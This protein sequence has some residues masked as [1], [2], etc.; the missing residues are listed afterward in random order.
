[1]NK[2]ASKR[3]KPKLNS[4]KKARPVT[5]ENADPV[6]GTSKDSLDVGMLDHRQ[7]RY[8]LAIIEE[9]H[10]SRAA[11]KL[12][13]SKQGMSQ[14]I[15]ALEQSLDA[16]LFE[17]GQFG[18][19]PTEFGRVLATH[20]HVIFA[21]GRKA[22]SEI[23]MLKLEH[24]GE[25]TFALGSSFSQWIGPAAIV[26]FSAKNPGVALKVANVHPDN[27]LKLLAEGQLD[28]IA[29]GDFADGELPKGVAR[30]KLFTTKDRVICAKTTYTKKRGHV[31]LR[32]LSDTK[33]VT[34]WRNDKTRQFIEGA[35]KGEGF[36]NSPSFTLCDNYAVSRSLVLNHGHFIVAD[37]VFFKEDIEEGKLIELNVPELEREMSYSVFYRSDTIHSRATLGLID[38]VEAVT[39]EAIGSSGLGK[40]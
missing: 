31:S 25:V 28:F 19:V 21:E 37:R 11:E 2:Q 24:R 13:I 18:A 29:T 23:Q 6:N 15:A 30:R 33:F 36:S 14:S 16:K 34:V 3:L 26:N 12:G 20:A 10:F 22:I 38:E 32:D 1:M 35:F 40:L 4:A 17:R 8:F 5:A 9:G 27:M 7:L 39:R